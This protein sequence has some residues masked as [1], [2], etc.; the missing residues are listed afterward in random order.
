VAASPVVKSV[1]LLGLK[2]RRMITHASRA[3]RSNATAAFLLDKLEEAHSSLL[4]AI[5]GLAELTRGPVPE[6]E[7]LIEVRWRVSEASLARRLLWGRIHAYLSERA[8]REVESSL[9]KL[10]EADMLL[11]RISTEHVGRWT[12]DAIIEDWPG[13]C[14]ASDAMRG[15]L[16][17][18]VELE[19]RLLYPILEALEGVSSS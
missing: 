13:Y 18:G 16:I 11:I 6:K 4:G 10:Q 15:R 5:E 19:K 14:R 17:E 2:E 7:Q 9:R 8:N 3:V 12:A 1:K